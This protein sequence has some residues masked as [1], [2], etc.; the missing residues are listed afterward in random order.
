MLIDLE[1]CTRCDECVRACVDAHTDG[2]SRLFLLGPR[3]GKFLVPTT[4]RSCLDPVCMIGCPV[5]SIQ[6]GD[7]REILIKDWCIGCGLCAKQ[8]PYES[9]QMHPL[10]G[11]EAPPEAPEGST[12]KEVKERAV[13]CDL[14]SGLPSQDPACV[15]ACPHE[16]AIRIDA[17][18][19]FPTS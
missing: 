3:F 15:Y 8:C 2:R 17:R 11:D 12:V 19:E 10:A 7:N 13:V 4:C 5:R 18:G 9:I 14:C 16:A 6:R 1:R